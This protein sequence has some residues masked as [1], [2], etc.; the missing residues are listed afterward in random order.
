[1][2]VIASAQFLSIVIRILKAKLI[3]V[4]LGPSGTGLLSVFTNLQMLGS[5]AAGLGLP[6]SGVRDLAAA[7]GDP[8]VVSRLR[9]V[10]VSTLAIQGGIA[11]AVIWTLREQLSVWLL[12]ET[13]QATEIG[14]VGIAVL[15]FLLSSSQRTLLQGMRRMGDLG[16]AMVLGTL[17]GAVAGI[18]AVWASGKEGLIWFLIAEPFAALLVSLYFVRRLPTQ[19]T[20]WPSVRQT[21]NYWLPMVRLGMAF[22]LGG[23][24]TTATLLFVRTLITR[25]LG[26]DAAGQFAAAVAITI[27]YVGFLMQAMS[28]D[29][30]PRISQVINS[31]DLATRLINDQMQLTL[32]LGG[33]IL[34]LMIGLAPWIIWVLYSAEFDT[35]ANL[36]QWQ[37]VGNVMKLAAWPLTFAF[38]AAA[39]SAV[40]FYLQVQFNL[41]FLSVIWLGLPTIHL[42]IAGISFF[43]GNVMHIVVTAGF[44]YRLNKF[45]WRTSNM[46]LF[47][48]HVILAISLLLL[49]RTFP[50]VG[51]I[52]AILL[53][54]LTALIGMHGV[55]TTIGPHGRLVS[56]IA[57]LYERIGYPIAPSK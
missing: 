35:A 21:W 10:L 18:L 6:Q 44:A 43:L 55:I 23:L 12:G 17:A 30:L 56:G 41:L 38:I 36:V 13:R 2:A 42:E 19:Q 15:L 14:L 5:Q 29:F 49:A 4:M 20:N 26:L 25:D 51:A 52:G 22:M 45:R 27:T 32:A 54:L 57:Q 11:M 28:T 37:M 9:K 3:A 34:L 47:A 50:H 31:Q 33:P 39:R 48:M 24:L 7:R 53:A 46:K 1:M 8:K 40:Y 16:R